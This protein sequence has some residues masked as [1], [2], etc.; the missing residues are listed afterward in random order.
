[1]ALTPPLLAS[2]SIAG[3]DDLREF[4]A[5]LEAYLPALAREALAEEQARGN[6]AKPTIYVDGRKGAPLDSVK[7]FGNITFVAGEGNVAAAV[8]MVDAFARAAAPR[9]SG[10]YGRSLR[11]FVNGRPA[12]GAPSVKQIGLRGN[13]E[14]VDLA[15]YAAMV[16]IMVP[17]GVIFGAFTQAARAFGRT[18]AIGFRYADAAD[19]GGHMEKPGTK[20]GRYFKVPVVSIGNP[21]STVFPGVM[22]SR[23][24][25]NLQHR[26]RTVRRYLR[27][28]GLL[29]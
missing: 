6:L 12:A 9:D 28:K 25:H 19:F 23:P 26:R 29:E 27:A 2:R 21:V 3:A 13:A 4:F 18:V 15:P 11:W 22:R 17:R 16:E 8:S 1:M 14:L 24:G 5:Y 7:T 20:G 10:H